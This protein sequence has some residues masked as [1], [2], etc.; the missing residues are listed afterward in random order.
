[1][2]TQASDNTYL[3]QMR[4]TVELFAQKVKSMFSS[5]TL[6]VE[7][8]Y[9]ETLKKEVVYCVESELHDHF[10]A[11]NQAEQHAMDGEK[12]KDILND[13]H[14]RTKTVADDAIKA[15]ARRGF[16]DDVQAIVD[17]FLI[18]MTT[19]CD[20]FVKTMKSTF[21]PEKEPQ[22]PLTEKD[23]YK[24]NVAIAKEYTN[25]YKQQT[26]SEELLDKHEVSSK[27]L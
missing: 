26:F 8:R 5:D 17:K 9:L 23:T 11:Q 24:E 25:K 16:V 7:T 3:S 13:L 12:L 20:S 14:Q 19:L 4:E 22:R 2:G 18:S 15:G 27:K 21:M 6:P 10:S 1:M